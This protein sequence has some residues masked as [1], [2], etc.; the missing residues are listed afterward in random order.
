VQLYIK[1]EKNT[2]CTFKIP[3]GATLLASNNQKIYCNQVIAEIKQDKNLIEEKDRKDLS[4]DA[5]GEV[6]LQN[7][8]LDKGIDSQGAT[9]IIS[10][11]RGLIWVLYGER[12]V[13]DSATKINVRVGQ[14]F[15][16]KEN[17]ATKKISN[18]YSGIV[19]FDNLAS[20]SE[21]NVINSSIILENGFLQKT[22]ETFEHLKIQT[23]NSQLLFKLQV[24]NNES[25]KHGQTVAF[26][27]ENKYKTE[28]GGIIYYSTVFDGYIKKRSKKRKFSGSLY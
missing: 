8:K 5:S 16:E 20:S 6:F 11:T 24:K 4:T 26:L 27:K 15:Q 22:S 21:I 13:L 23:S 10:K 9:K 1:N 7:V 28:S 14:K 25:L 19:N 2:V 17:I 18:N 12:Y 3:R